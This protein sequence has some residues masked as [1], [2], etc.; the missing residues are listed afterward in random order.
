MIVMAADS[1]SQRRRG[2]AMRTALRVLSLLTIVA[3]GGLLLGFGIGYPLS[4]VDFNVAVAKQI[5]HNALIGTFDPE[6]ALVQP[7]DLPSTFAQS[8][9]DLSLFSIVG[10][11]F[12][13]EQPKVDGQLGD[14][15]IRSFA[16]SDK[17]FVIS[18]VVRVKAAKQASDYIQQVQRAF[19]GCLPKAYFRVDKVRVK[20]K[21]G[22][23]DPPV[24]DYVSYTLE[25]ETPGPTQV[26]V[27]F[28]VGD[29]VVAIQYLGPSKPTQTLLKDA[30]DAI[31]RRTAPKDFGALAV[32]DGV[33]P[34]PTEAPTTAAPTSAPPPTTTTA[35]PATTTTVKKKKKPA[36]AT[37]K[38]PATQPPAPP[39]SGP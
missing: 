34:V 14:K 25:P 7:S 38:A 10:A 8:D 9:V 19:D 2:I 20:I 16:T 4:K 29:V 11:S 18:E 35:V 13:G 30:Q 17:Q 31:L 33:L 1:D 28:Q 39:T 27:F 6:L 37:T 22:Q 5:D 36:T 3:I 26:I 15:L 32:V 24:T 23:P 21:A 12:C